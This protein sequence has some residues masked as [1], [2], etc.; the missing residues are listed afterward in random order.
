M[1][2]ILALLHC[3]YSFLYGF[4]LLYFLTWSVLIFGKLWWC[5][6]NIVHANNHALANKFNL[7]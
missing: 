5:R 7:D 4:D 3:I 1:E 2:G 6:S